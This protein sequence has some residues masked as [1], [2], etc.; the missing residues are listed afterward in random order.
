MFYGTKRAAIQ[1][2]LLPQHGPD[3]Q[4]TLLSGSFL[5][6]SFNSVIIMGI[7]T[8]PQ[9]WGLLL[10]RISNIVK[11][12]VDSSNHWTGSVEHDQPLHGGQVHAALQTGE[13]CPQQHD[14]L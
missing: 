14:S 7:F 9:S 12:F 8:T 5:H 11:T 4:S 3:A 2:E 1:P 10:L 13:G 6:Y